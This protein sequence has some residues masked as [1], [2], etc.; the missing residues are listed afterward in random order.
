VNNK[1]FELTNLSFFSNILF[2]FESVYQRIKRAERRELKNRVE[3]KREEWSRDCEPKS[4]NLESK[5]KRR[6]RS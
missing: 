4:F 2:S 3:E 1:Y 5:N 6:R